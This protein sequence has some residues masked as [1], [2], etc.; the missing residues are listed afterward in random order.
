[1]EGIVTISFTLEEPGRGTTRVPVM[2]INF[3]SM[4]TSRKPPIQAYVEAFESENHIKSFYLL[5]NDLEQ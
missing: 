4:T 1:V 5:Q 2:G 3:V